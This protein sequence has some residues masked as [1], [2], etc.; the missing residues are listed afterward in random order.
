VPSLKDGIFVLSL[1]DMKRCP[2]YIFLFVFV[3]SG[4]LAHAQAPSA[5]AGPY[6][7]FCS[8]GP[9]GVTLGGAPTASGGISPYTYQWQPSVSL[10]NAQAANPLATVTVTTT[11]TVTV[12]GSN[13]ESAKDTVT[14]RLYNYG[15]DAGRDTIIKQGQTITLHGHANGAT[16]VNWEPSNYN[17]YNQNSLNPDVFPGVTITYTFSAVYPGGCVLYDYVTVTVIPGSDLFF[18]NTFSPNG[19]GANDYFYIGNIEKYPN[20]VLE[21][22][23]RYGQKVFSKT[24]YQ[25]DW[26]GKYLNNELPAGTYFYIL[27]TKTDS[28]GKHH[29][30]VNIIR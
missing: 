29:G 8:S 24:P 12:T 27:D 2:A 14:I 9:V 20:N 19:D 21:I 23:N 22:Y 13:G 11:F 6:Q 25:N 16:H 1:S 18:F 26:D 17:I 10:N 4:F 15:I 30:Q 3:F 28:G 5:D 7:V